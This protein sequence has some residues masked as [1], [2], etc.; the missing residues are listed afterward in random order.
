[1]RRNAAFIGSAIAAMFA[2]Q[3][4]FG[5]VLADHVP[6]DAIVYVG[7]A[8]ADAMQSKDSGTH[9]EALL[10]ES[11]A[12]EVMTTYLDQVEAQL[13][14][15]PPEALQA[16]KMFRSLATP[17]WK[18][19]AAFYV[20]KPDLTDQR[21]PH[22]KI[23]I[24]SKAGDQAQAIAAD[25]MKKLPKQRAGEPS[26]TALAKDGL[27][28]FCVS[29]EADPMLDLSKGAL[30]ATPTFKSALGQVHPDGIVTTFVDYQAIMSAVESG[31]AIHAPEPSA[32]V[33]AFLDASGLRG[34][35]QLVATSGFEGKD[36]YTD[37]FVATDSERTGLLK[38]SPPGALNTDILKIVPQDATVVRTLRFDPAVLTAELRNTIGKTDENALQKY[39]AVFGFL[40]QALGANVEQSVLT[41]LGSDWVVYSA[42]EIGGG[43]LLGM[44]VVNKLDDA[45]AMQKGVNT[46]APNFTRW[47]NIAMKKAGLP[48]PINL[49]GATTKIGDVTVN[50]LATPLFA[51]SYVIDGD[52]LYM[53]FYPQ[54]VGAAVRQAHKG[55][56]SILD[57][58]KFVK[59]VKV[60]KHDKYDAVGYY[61]LPTSARYGSMYSMLLLV[62][63]Y[64]GMADLFGITLPEPLMPPLDVMLEHL[65]PAADVNWSDSAGF[66]M[67]SVM[68]FPGA[69]MLNDQAAAMSL[70]ASSAGMIAAVAMPAMQK[71][72]FQAQHVQSMS[73]LR[74]IG[75]AMMM[76]ANDNGG[77]FPDSIA[78]LLTTQMLT[79]EVF[80]NPANGPMEIPADIRSDPEAL[81]QFTVDHSDYIYVGAGKTSQSGPDEVLAYENPEGAENGINILFG[82]GHVEFQ[83]M[84][85]AL[86]TIADIKPRHGV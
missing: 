16:F 71:A 10:K 50:Y 8:G 58:P 68:S 36:W 63:R 82:D 15:Q 28:T 12:N 80:D 65:E 39:N 17:L 38:V 14:K 1:M 22:F 46:V 23:A 24:L 33:K 81:T 35:K 21:M 69:V 77:K 30:A 7:W 19:P 66:H 20:A 57:N 52:Y 5:Q 75:V 25:L 47:V 40:Q 73:N 60:L 84:E 29:S 51:P 13:A 72:R 48:V 64:A 85:Q 83:Q 86:Q 43:S 67:H 49:H 34:L 26:V 3:H 62:T 53:G 54:T 32:K 11:R 9:F 59:A 4:A 2:S 76:H 45:A 27:L 55:K 70:G 78:P 74:Q 41:P 42:P 37:V 79:P 56:G 18:Y 6:G 44:V 31:M 61:D